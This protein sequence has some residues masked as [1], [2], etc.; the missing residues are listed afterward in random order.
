MTKGGLSTVPF[1]RA[2]GSWSWIWFNCQSTRELFIF[3]YVGIVR[4]YPVYFISYILLP[5]VYRVAISDNYRDHDP[6]TRPSSPWL[7]LLPPSLQCRS[8]SSVLQRGRRSVVGFQ[9]TP[10]HCPDGGTTTSN[11]DDYPSSASRDEPAR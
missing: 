7:L 6:P 9:A 5:L 1:P 10:Y 11:G 4:I 3:S 2:Q 8:L